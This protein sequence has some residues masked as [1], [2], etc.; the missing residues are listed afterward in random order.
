MT[1]GEKIFLICLLCFAELAKNSELLENQL[2][3]R[4]DNMFG[5]V[6]L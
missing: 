1:I 2:S 5:E 3:L 4:N 6:E